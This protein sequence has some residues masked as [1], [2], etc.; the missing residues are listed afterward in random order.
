MSEITDRLVDSIL[1][2]ILE[3]MDCKHR[4]SRNENGAHIS[5]D[6]SLK[7]ELKVRNKIIAILEPPPEKEGK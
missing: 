7:N 4:I 1:E 2:V 6:Y 5:A 3:D